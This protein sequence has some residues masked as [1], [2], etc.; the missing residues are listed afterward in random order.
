MHPILGGCA[1]YLVYRVLRGGWW[2]GSPRISPGITPYPVCIFTSVLGHPC[3]KGVCTGVP[4]EIGWIWGYPQKCTFWGIW[5]NGQY[6]YFGVFWSFP[7]MPDKGLSRDM[8]K[9]TKYAQNGKTGVRAGGVPHCVM[10]SR[11]TFVHG[12]HRY[13]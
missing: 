1:T 13:P 9:M 12:F 5:Q 4:L 3:T 2:M 8:G 11:S 10:N 7:H 6:R